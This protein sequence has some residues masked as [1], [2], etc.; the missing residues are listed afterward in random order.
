MY[1]NEHINACS[2]FPQWISLTANRTRFQLMIH[3]I[4]LVKYDIPKSILTELYIKAQQL[5]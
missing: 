1:L 2:K 5:T 3:N 4:S